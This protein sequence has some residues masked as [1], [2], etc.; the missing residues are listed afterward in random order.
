MIPVMQNR[1]YDKDRGLR[2]N[3]MQ[4]AMASILDLKL[5]QVPDFFEG[6]K[7]FWTNVMQFLEARGLMLFEPGKQFV[8]DCFYLAHG[9]SS[10][11]V[12][13]TVVHR[14]G[15]LIHDPHPSG[16]GIIAVEWIS[17]LIP[18]DPAQR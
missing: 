10:R 17:M 2:G 7:G 15:K 9:L 12:H 3:C 11:G 1:F 5:D 4:A 16:E 13:H 6:P 14:G 18:I 8:P